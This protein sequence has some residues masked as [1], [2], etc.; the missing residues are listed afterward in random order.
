MEKDFKKKKKKKKIFDENGIWIEKF[1]DEDMIMDEKENQKADI[2]IDLTNKYILIHKCIQ[3]T[4]FNK[5]GGKME[6]ICNP[7]CL[8]KADLVTDTR[9]IEIKPFEEAYQAMGQ[10]MRYSLDLNLRSLKKTLVVF[11]HQNKTELKKS[12]LIET[13][14]LI[15]IDVIFI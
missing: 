7:K 14:N 2:T 4:L 11:G 6:Y 5:L 8:G 1:D 3:R 13:F 15:G 10:L 12:M 9:L